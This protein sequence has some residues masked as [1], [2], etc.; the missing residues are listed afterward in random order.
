MMQRSHVVAW[1][2][3]PFLAPSCAAPRAVAIPDTPFL[4]E[5]HERHPV[6][7]DPRA[8]DVRAIAVD[9]SGTAWAATGA[10]VYFLAP[11]EARWSKPGATGGGGG[12]G[13]AFDVLGD[14][15]GSVWAG[16]W[17]GLYRVTRESMQKVPGIQH[18]IAA[19]CAEGDG[20]AAAGPDGLWR[21]SG[22]AVSFREL[23]FSRGVRGL[24]AEPAGGLWIATA[25]GLYLDCPGA[26]V[27][28]QTGDGELSTD[29]RGIAFSSDGS[30]WSAGLGGIVVHRDSRVVGQHTPGTGLPSAKV[31]CISRG[32]DGR[33]WAGTALG[34]ARFDGAGW[35]LRHG[36]RWLAD[37]DVRDVAFGPGG[38][39]WIATAR[40][41]SVIRHAEMTLSEKAAHY[42]AA[43][44]ARHVR[45][46]GLVEKCRLCVP[47]DLSTWEPQDDDNDGQYTAMY[48]AMQSF[49]Y[50]ATRDPAAREAAAQA[51]HALQ[52]LQTVTGTRGFVARTVVPASWTSMAD[53]NEVISDAEW[54]DRRVREPRD[55]RVPNHWRPSADGKWL[56]KGDTSSDEITGHMYGYLMYHDL[57]ADDAEK[58]LVREQ[59][60]R[61]VDAIVEDGLVLKD[62]DGTHTQW[63][64]WAPEKL[65]RDP[66]WA[67]ERGVNSVEILSYLKLARHVTGEA[68]YEEQYRRLIREHHYDENVRRA[69]TVNSSWR[70]HIDDELLALAYPALLL[71]E[72]DPELRRLYLESLEWWHAAVRGEQSPFYDFTHRALSGADANIDGA[73]AF[74]RD[75]PLDLIRWE[76]D[77]TK[78]EDLRLVRSP[79]L[80]HV[81]TD[82]LPP[83]SERCT[84]RWD[85]NPWRAIQGDG[86]RTESD[87]V[88]WLLPYWMGRYHGFLRTERASQ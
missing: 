36:K 8:N 10:G 29:V 11:G 55:K 78:R 64:V 45:E 85:D 69:K 27:T 30:L 65:N 35:S 49:R 3:L 40:G 32:P 71:H 26:S 56:W 9:P 44:A 7:G 84:V 41:V 76:V 14:A 20:I 43:C 59:V 63:G 37:D 86:G 70:T 75:A 58:K 73:V 61:I 47:G 72:E 53:P 87:G 42:H 19:L 62:V 24:L 16:L 6:A 21:V 13:P 68:K 38:A 1:A 88:Y 77:N 23:P 31:C 50:A 80:E 81:Q 79:E 51:F 33:M 54:A 48:L 57:A 60:A 5:R 12:V 67:M 74:L 83:P 28:L 52:F 46:P 4:Q 25:M 17:D 22:D 39:A 34:V 66:D 18:P 2:V 82:R 15:R